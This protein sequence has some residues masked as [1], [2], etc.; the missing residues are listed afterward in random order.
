MKE[1][2]VRTTILFM[3]LMVLAVGSVQAM[4]ISG[5]ITT[6]RTI[7]DQSR[8]VGNVNCTVVGAPCIKFGAS[9]IKLRLNGFTISGQANPTFGCGGGS[10][11]RVMRMELSAKPPLA[12]ALR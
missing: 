11:V 10:A 2:I 1:N 8:L 3:G 6:T 12:T 4:D 9:N 5:A 7:T